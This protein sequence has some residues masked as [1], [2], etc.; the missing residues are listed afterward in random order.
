MDYLPDD[1]KFLISLQFD[2]LNNKDYETFFTCPGFENL[3][4]NERF[5]KFYWEEM[6]NDGY[7]WY[8]GYEEEFQFLRL[9]ILYNSKKLFDI[10]CEEGHNKLLLNILAREHVQVDIIHNK[11]LTTKHSRIKEILSKYIPKPE[12]SSRISVGYIVVG[13]Y[14]EGN[15]KN[16]FGKKNKIGDRSINATVFGLNSVC[17]SSNCFVIGL[18]DDKQVVRSPSNNTFTIDTGIRGNKRGLY[19]L[20]APSGTGKP[21]LITSNGQIVTQKEKKKVSIREIDKNIDD[22]KPI[23]YIS[24]G[25]REFGFDETSILSEISDNGKINTEALLALA[26]KEIIELKKEVA[27]LK[28]IISKDSK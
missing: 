9:S 12:S 18:R 25:K 11:Y 10:A 2:L 6:I 7:R 13:D 8:G 17:T 3:F 1:I 5:W 19:Y 15:N 23:S 26:V 24:D 20:N 16:I 22:L 28:D 21:L 27:M 4:D 14:I